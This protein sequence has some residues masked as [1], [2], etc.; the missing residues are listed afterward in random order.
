MFQK[1]KNAIFFASDSELRSAQSKNSLKA[2]QMKYNVRACFTAGENSVQYWLQT[3]LSDKHMH[4][5]PLFAQ[6]AGS[7][8]FC[9]W[10]IAV[11]MSESIRITSMTIIMMVIIVKTTANPSLEGSNVAKGELESMQM[12]LCVFWSQAIY[13]TVTSTLVIIWIF[14]YFP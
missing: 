6:S 4:F 13:W 12:S 11:S 10:M 1:I 2:K 3:Y 14:P 7:S 8:I 5:M 9:R